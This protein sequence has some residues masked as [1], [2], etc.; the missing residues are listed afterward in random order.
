MP[1]LRGLRDGHS[2]VLTTDDDDDTRQHVRLYFFK[3][4]PRSPEVPRHRTVRKEIAE[5]DK[6]GETCDKVLKVGLRQWSF[7]HNL[8]SSRI[9]F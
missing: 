1:F 7:R 9:L 6:K 8:F 3:V 4:P 5:K 2:L